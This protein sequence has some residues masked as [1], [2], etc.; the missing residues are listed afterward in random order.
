MKTIAQLLGE[1]S[2]LDAEIARAYQQLHTQL[3][4]TTRY[5]LLCFTHRGTGTDWKWC[6]MLHVVTPD[7][8]P[9]PGTDAWEDYANQILCA[10]SHFGIYVQQEGGGAGQPFA[11]KPCVQHFGN[12][13]V[14]TQHG[15]LDV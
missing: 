5:R 10:L 14:I 6:A 1:R 13:I 4:E 2:Q 3:P 12:H 8:A 15:G 11:Y 7:P 9:N